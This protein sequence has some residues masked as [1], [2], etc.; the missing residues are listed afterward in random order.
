MQPVAL[1]HQRGSSAHSEVIRRNPPNIFISYRRSDSAA[2]T[3]RIFERLVERFGRAPIFIDVD[4]IPYGSDFRAHIETILTD[5]DVLL[6]VIGP[7]WRGSLDQGRFRIDDRDDPVRVEVSTAMQNGTRLIPVLVEGATMPTA[8]DL[9]DGIKDLSY[10]NAAVLDVGQ[11]FHHDVNRLISAIDGTS[12]EEHPATTSRATWLA[13]IASE[14]L[15]VAGGTT[16]AV[17]AAAAAIPIAAHQAALS[18]P[19]PP[20][21]VYL[22]LAVLCATIISSIWIL[23]AMPRLR[24]WIIAAAAAVLMGTASVYLFAVST[25]TY[26][27]PTTKERWAK[28][29]VCTD[30][31]LLVYKQRCP[32]LG[33]DE[34]RNA[35]FEA[36]R[37]WTSR[38]VSIVRV[39][40]L[41]LWLLSFAML[42]LLVS[43]GLTRSASAAER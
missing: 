43:A 41:A 23:R 27:T 29:Y 34:L 1:S 14:T 35:E 6:V 12:A 5:C 30:D 28:G 18:P 21:V 40:M 19:W 37:L 17:I 42:G 9:P 13:N 20:G 4:K 26:Q 33:M 24:P 7:R 8:D 3:H 36:E 11:N 25:F 38:S 16:L 22:T 32:Q 31:A 39:S 15:S 10:L 2:I